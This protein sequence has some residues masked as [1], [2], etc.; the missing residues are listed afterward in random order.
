MNRSANQ[1]GLTKAEAEKVMGL[2]LRAAIPHEADNFSLA[3][4]HY[5]PYCPRFPRDTISL[6]F[7]QIAMEIVDQLERQRTA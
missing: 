2:R 7:K 3:I 5:E 4:T 6:M 1:E